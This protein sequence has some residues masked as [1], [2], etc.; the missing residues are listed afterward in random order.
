MRVEHPKRDSLLRIERVQR[1]GLLPELEMGKEVCVLFFSERRHL[2][3]K[4]GMKT[5]EYGLLSYTRPEREA[6]CAG[7]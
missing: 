4:V 3:R 7:G 5:E 2:L 6:C 1:S